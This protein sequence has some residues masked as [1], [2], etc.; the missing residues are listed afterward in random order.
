MHVWPTL[1]ANVRGNLERLLSCLIQMGQ[2]EVGDGGAEEYANYAIVR[3]ELEN[4][5]SDVLGFSSDEATVTEGKLNLAGHIMSFCHG[6]GE[7]WMEIAADRIVESANSS[8]RVSTTHG[9]TAGA[10]PMWTRVISTRAV[11]ARWRPVQRFWGVFQIYD[12]ADISPFSFRSTI[13][14]MH[15]RKVTL[16]LRDAR[17]KDLEQLSEKVKA[18]ACIGLARALYR[19]QEFASQEDLNLIKL[20]LQRFMALPPNLFVSAFGQGSSFDDVETCQASDPTTLMALTM[21][22]AI[23][24][25]GSRNL[26]ALIDDAGSLGL[27]D[28]RR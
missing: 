1:N 4:S 6:S 3:R 28:R 7:E 10:D 21:R 11:F 22:G 14:E 15:F 19:V 25:C 16:A 12:P 26:V 18:M 24:V 23:S 13:S 17:P 20:T 8:S 5:I 9:G 2:A 27:W